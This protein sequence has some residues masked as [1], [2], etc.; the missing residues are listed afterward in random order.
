MVE[1]GLLM[2]AKMDT[3]GGHAHSLACARSGR[4]G[5]AL[6]RIPA[7]HKNYVVFAQALSL[8]D[9]VGPACPVGAALDR[10]RSLLDAPV[11]PGESGERC[12]FLLGYVPGTQK[13]PGSSTVPVLLRES[14]AAFALSSWGRPILSHVIASV[15]SPPDP[16]RIESLRSPDS[17]GRGLPRINRYALVV[18]GQTSTLAIAGGITELHLRDG[19]DDPCWSRCSTREAADDHELPACQR[20]CYVNSAN[21]G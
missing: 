7:R 20:G 11:A 1:N 16:K 9:R 5:R 19:K 8:F 10:F 18:D 21:G 2:L 12:V 13:A 3:Q 17:A 14:G 6:A 15:K 4:R